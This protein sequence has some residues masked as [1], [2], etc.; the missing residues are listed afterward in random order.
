M[1]PLSKSPVLGS[2]RTK[3][4]TQKRVVYQFEIFAFRFL[5]G[6]RFF[7]AGVFA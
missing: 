4:N 3:A 2:K 7:G 6:P 5:Y 1:R